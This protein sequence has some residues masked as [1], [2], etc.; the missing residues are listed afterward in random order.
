MW[1][2]N[3]LS[4]FFEVIEPFNLFHKKYEGC[5]LT[6]VFLKSCFEEYLDE[7][8][9]ISATLNSKFYDIEYSGKG[10][11]CGASRKWKDLSDKQI[12]DIMNFIF[13]NI[14]E[15]ED[16]RDMRMLSFSNSMKVLYYIFY[17][18]DF[19]S[20][21]MVSGNYSETLF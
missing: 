12:E 4:R 1:T 18:V 2:I 17:G 11:P 5:Q 3:D 13:C 7:I 6:K 14:D 15:W 21:K 10:D 20:W 19:C 9:S 16:L 8:I